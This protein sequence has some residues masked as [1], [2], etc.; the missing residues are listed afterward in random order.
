MGIRE[1]T[2]AV[3]FMKNKGKVVLCAGLFVGVNTDFIEEE[4]FDGAFGNVPKRC[5]RT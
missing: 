1:V 2:I 4:V 5:R 3:I